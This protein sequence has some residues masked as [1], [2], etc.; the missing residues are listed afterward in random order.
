MKV[1]D[2]NWESIG[3]SARGESLILQPIGHVESAFVEG[4]A[5]GQEPPETSRII[6]EPAFTDGLNG[7]SPGEEILVIFW[8]HRSKGYQLRQHPKG[9]TTRQKRGVFSLRSP[10]R[11]SPIGV[12]QV[13]ITALDGNVICVTGLDAFNG[14]PVLDLKP[15]GRGS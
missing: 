7:L 15:V 2:V 13:R 14:T 10:H 1:R 9:D 3:S 4:G 6:L 5:P 11:P 12:T 8:F